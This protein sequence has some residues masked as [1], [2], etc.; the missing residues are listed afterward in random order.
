V[1]VACD[2]SP[3][4]LESKHF[5]VPVTRLVAV[6]DADSDVVEDVVVYLGAE[7]SV[8]EVRREVFAAAAV[9]EALAEMEEVVLRKTRAG[10]N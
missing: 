5:I 10:G 8:N 6:C 4:P 9:D 1:G 3:N 7:F 2:D